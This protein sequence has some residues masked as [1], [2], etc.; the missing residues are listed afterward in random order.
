MIET[1]NI[2]A[3]KFKELVEAE[4]AGAKPSEDMADDELG[5]FLKAKGVG[6]EQGCPDQ[7]RSSGLTRK[8]T[9]PCMSRSYLP[10]FWLSRGK[11]T[12]RRC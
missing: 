9:G 1:G 7:A 4:E 5:A 11:P 10:N 8:Q 2:T 3:A 6:R 12:D